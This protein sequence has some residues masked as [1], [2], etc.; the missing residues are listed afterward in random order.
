MKGFGIIL[1]VPTINI[2]SNKND[3]VS[4]TK[5]KQTTEKGAL[6][7]GGD[8]RPLSAGGL[9]FGTGRDPSLCGG[10]ICKYPGS[11]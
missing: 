10:G 3:L 4:K 7:Q 6:K 5:S 1:L 9:S 11:L 8:G 2:R